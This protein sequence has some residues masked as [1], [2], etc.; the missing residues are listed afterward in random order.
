MSYFSKIGRGQLGYAALMLNPT[1]VL[2]LVSSMLPQAPAKA[3]AP[4]VAWMGGCWELTRGPRHTVEQWTAPEGGTL[5]GVSRTVAGGKTVEYEFLIIREREGG[6]EYVAKP[7]GQPEAVFPAA[8][9][10]ATEVV[11]ENAA[12]DFP[13][14]IIYRKTPDNGLAAR[15]EGTMNGKERGID[16]AY[17]AAACGK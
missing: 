14:R 9:V 12:H 11:F 7:S 3:A 10:S 5:L 8:R 15:I 16:F 4:D 17:R 1:I 2:L 6:L 13:Q